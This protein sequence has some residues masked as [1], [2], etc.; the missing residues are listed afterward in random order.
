MSFNNRHA[1]IISYLKKLLLICR[2]G[3]RI[4]QQMATVSQAG[5]TKVKG[6]HWWLCMGTTSS[7]HSRTKNFCANSAALTAYQS[8]RLSHSRYWHAHAATSWAIPGAGLPGVVHHRPGFP[9]HEVRE[10]WQVARC[11]NTVPPPFAE[12]L[13]R[14]N[15]PEMCEARER[16]A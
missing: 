2:D 3:Q 16:A 1:S 10:G 4:Y 5:R 6:K 15:M 13:V 12:A 7:A 11:G 9:G 8:P 14:A